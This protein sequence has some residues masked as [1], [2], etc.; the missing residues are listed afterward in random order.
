MFNYTNTTSTPNYRLR[1]I[2]WLDFEEGYFEEEGFLR[3]RGAPFLPPSTRGS[4][5]QPG[6][7]VCQGKQESGSWFNNTGTCENMGST[8]R[9]KPNKLTLAWSKGTL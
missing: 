7:C 8:P 1:E 2:V 6:P 4:S 9:I 3:G 5:G